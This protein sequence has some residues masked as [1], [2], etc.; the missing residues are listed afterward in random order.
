MNKTRK[1]AGQKIL[2]LEKLSLSST[3]KNRN[4]SK[5]SHKGKARP[6][7]IFKR[8]RPKTV[9]PGQ[10]KY[11]HLSKHLF[12][13]KKQ[14]K[15]TRSKNADSN[16]TQINP[17]RAFTSHT[18]SKLVS[19][20]FIR[21]K[22][23]TPIPDQGFATSST[24]TLKPNS[25]FMLLLQK[26]ARHV[27]KP[28]ASSFAKSTQ[29]ISKNTKN[30]RRLPK[31]L[32]DIKSNY[33]GTPVKASANHQKPSLA[34]VCAELFGPLLTS[35]KC[36]ESALG[37]LRVLAKGSSSVVFGIVPSP[38]FEAHVAKRFCRSRL[39]RLSVLKQLTVS[40]LVTRRPKCTFC[41]T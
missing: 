29:R 15:Q 9:V 11:L 33:F 40:P 41:S 17:K 20:T 36:A 27:G 10:P 12:R 8:S 30:A 37:G 25:R 23:T 14:K 16:K 34:Q 32:P 5:R 4:L 31:Q 28:R 24:Q 18:S 22:S 19:K 6:A 26:M 3:I 38:R 13:L 21:K 7:T 1:S 35:V 2:S 39:R